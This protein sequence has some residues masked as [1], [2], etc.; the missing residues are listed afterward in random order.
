MCQM[1]PFS[2]GSDAQVFSTSQVLDRSL[3]DPSVTVG[4][5]FPGT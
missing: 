1:W 5:D 3:I 2:V 4:V